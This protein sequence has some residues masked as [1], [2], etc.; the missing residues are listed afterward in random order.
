[1]WR[2]F[3]APVSAVKPVVPDVEFTSAPLETR[4]ST[5]SSCP[6]YAASPIG[7]KPS[8]DTAFARDGSRSTSAFT[9]SRRPV[10]AASWM[11]RSAPIA[12]RFAAAT[13]WPE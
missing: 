2:E 10:A 1:M 7:A 6:R 8:A 4:Y 9:R 12:I 13:F 11:S 5:T 3:T